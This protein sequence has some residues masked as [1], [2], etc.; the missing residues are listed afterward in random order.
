M[1]GEKYIVAHPGSVIMFSTLDEAR[2]RADAFRDSRIVK[3]YQ[4][5]EIETHFPRGTALP[6][7]MPPKRTA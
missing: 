2:E 5:I 3:V 6:P 1:A 7:P 4:L